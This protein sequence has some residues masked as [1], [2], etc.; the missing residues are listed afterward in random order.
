M[1]KNLN[2]SRNSKVNNRSS[3]QTKA[4]TQRRNF[5]A[6]KRRLVSNQFQLLKEQEAPSGSG[7]PANVRR[8]ATPK[9]PP[10]VIGQALND[11]KVTLSAIKSWGS[12]IHFRLIR[13]Q[14]AIMTSS[15]TDYRVVKEN[16]CKAKMPY[17]T[18]TPTVNKVKKLVLK[19]LPTE[20][21]ADEVTEDLK[22]KISD[23]VSIL[24]LKARNF[25]GKASSQSYVLTFP[26][27]KD[28]KVVRQ[29]VQLVCNFRIKW[30]D[31]VK[32]RQF[33]ST[34][35]YRCQKFGHVADNCGF[36][37]RCVKCSMDHE[38]KSCPKAREES[39]KCANCGKDHPASYRGCE[40]HKKYEK[41]I[42]P[43]KKI[44]SPGK[45]SMSRKLY[46]EVVKKTAAKP[47]QH[48][49]DPSA[50]PMDTDVFENTVD[51]QKQLE[52]VNTFMSINDKV[53]QSFGM[54]FLDLVEQIR[55]YD[56]E[57][58]KCS[59]DVSK[60]LTVSMKFISK[61]LENKK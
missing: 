19:G 5:E 14:H 8:D 30:E 24:Q 2:P 41:S 4:G 31:Y 40:T 26:W 61:M 17:Y 47:Q 43:K 32:P 15:E 57:F 56:A 21:S 52:C 39:A 7:T 13:G 1:G 55:E 50:V 11:A 49:N 45:E 12:D 46:S 33:R 51:G 23:V 59:G 35:C 54:E 53:K 37:A 34:Q 48:A 6:D 3:T 18:Y 27:S 28:I 42:R 16:L 9:M 25:N 20:F 22:S 29:S 10:I 38:S 58:T 44:S 60:E 36:D